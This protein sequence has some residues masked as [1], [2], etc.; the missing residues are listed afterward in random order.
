MYPM[1]LA[2]VLEQFSSYGLPMLVCENGIATHDDQLRCNFLTEHLRVIAQALTDGIKILGYVHWSL[3]DNF[4]WHHGYAARFGLAQVDY[5][6]LERRT[7]PSAE[8]F[9]KICRERR[10]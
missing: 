6:T 9:A 2:T 7:R 10:V 3:I 4:E 5:E 8:L 1:G